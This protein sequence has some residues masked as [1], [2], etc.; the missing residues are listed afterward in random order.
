MVPEKRNANYMSPDRP[1]LQ[2][3]RLL[4]REGDQSRAR[5]S[6]W[7]EVTD[8]GAWGG[9]GGRNLRGRVREEGVTRRKSS[10][11]LQRAPLSLL[12]NTELYTSRVKLYKTQQIMTGFKLNN[13]QGSHR[14]E[15]I[16]ALT[17]QTEEI[18]K[19]FNQMTEW[20]HHSSRDRLA[21]E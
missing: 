7:V 6:L 12:L 16:R 3:G 14:L 17:S 13:S 19:V 2:P 1:G 21:L 10:R 4:C 15:E 5:Q 20:S 9:S 8:T 11:N 18:L